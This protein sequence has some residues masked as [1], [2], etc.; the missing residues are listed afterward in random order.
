M[1][2]PSA[3]SSGKLTPR[4]D[5]SN[6]SHSSDGYCRASRQARCWERLACQHS[7]HLIVEIL[8]QT[9]RPLVLE[10]YGWLGCDEALELEEQL[11]D[12][13]G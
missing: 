1:R 6:R 7:S 2:R 13:F 8:R 9:V 11:D 5:T 3:T 12:L 10:A 4:L